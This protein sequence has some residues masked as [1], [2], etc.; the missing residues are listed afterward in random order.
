MYQVGRCQPQ[1]AQ[2]AECSPESKMRVTSQ[3]SEKE[4]R[5]QNSITDPEF[6]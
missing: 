3:R 5:R 2:L 1:S 4:S 6:T